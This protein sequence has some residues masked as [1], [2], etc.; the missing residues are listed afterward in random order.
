MEIFS[1]AEGDGS[2][3]VFVHAAVA[4][5]KMWDPQVTCFSATHQVVTVDLRG[6]GQT[7]LEPGSF[8]HS[9]D[10]SRV[11]DRMAIGSAVFVGASLGG[12]VVLDLV[13]SHPDRVKGIVLVSSALPGFSWSPEVVAFAEAEDDA[14]DRNDVEAAVE[15][16]LEFWLD[17]PDR[18]SSSLSPEQRA[19]VGAMQREAIEHIVNA[20]FESSAELASPDL[21]ERLEKI[22]KPVM[23]IV[24]DQD[25]D[26]MRA[27]S[28]VLEQRI[29]GADLHVISGA[30][31]LP[32]YEMPDQF[33]A[34][35]RTFLQEHSL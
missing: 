7:R 6:F 12:A 3:L 31:H 32:S 4:N 27:I 25:A 26:D 21:A 28:G 1:R 14:I 15:L 13:L 17:G 24:G 18:T 8:T 33:N 22:E 5:S 34:L 20:D 10:L 35:L 2:A 11:L 19:A 23:V 30:A 29:R 9:A 16:N